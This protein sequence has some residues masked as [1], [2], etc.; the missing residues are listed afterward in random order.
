MIAQA[1]LYIKLKVILCLIEY[2]KPELMMLIS[3]KMLELGS[4]NYSKPNFTNITL[5]H[6]SQH[7]FTQH[8]VIVS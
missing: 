8:Y 1:K 7:L 2:R 4:E 3:T 6:F 5:F